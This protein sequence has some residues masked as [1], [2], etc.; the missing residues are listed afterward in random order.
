M[1]KVLFVCMGNICRSPSAEGVFR[2]LVQ[3]AG[4]AGQIV[5]DSCGTHDYHVGGPPDERSTAHAK[6]R[7]YDLSD[8][9]ARQLHANDFEAFDY[10]LVMDRTNLGGTLKICPPGKE[11]KVK[12]FLT[13]SPHLGIDEVPDPYYGGAK[14][15][16]HVLDLVEDAS[17]SLLAQIRAE[18]G[19]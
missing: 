1:P 13:L 3:E 14:G 17:K 12:L 10:I 6:R 19:L 5:I 11:S 18:H 9:R 8:L 15:F 2:H 4:L 16:D 7:G